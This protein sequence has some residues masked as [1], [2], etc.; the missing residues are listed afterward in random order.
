MDCTLSIHPRASRSLGPTGKRLSLMRSTTSLKVHILNVRLL[1]LGTAIAHEDLFNL[2][3]LSAKQPELA[4][5]FNC[6]SG[7]WNNAFFFMGMVY[8]R[9]Y[10][11]D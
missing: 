10:P 9:L 11:G 3:V 4:A 6:A 5:L 2:T 8:E 1:I 7:A